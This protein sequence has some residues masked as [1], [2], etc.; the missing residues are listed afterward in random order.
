MYCFVMVSTLLI[1][2]SNY[3]WSICHWSTVQ[4]VTLIKLFILIGWWLFFTWVCLGT[5]INSNTKITIIWFLFFGW[6]FVTFFFSFLMSLGYIRNYWC[7]QKVCLGPIWLPL[8]FGTLSDVFSTKDSA[9]KRRI[10]MW[11]KVA[12]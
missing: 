1:K 11:Y 2:Y 4:K 3:N 6:T 10:Y 12:F 5:L 9:E 7:S 8:R